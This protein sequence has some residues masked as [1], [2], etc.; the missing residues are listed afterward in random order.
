MKKLIFI[1]IIFNTCFSQ[2]VHYIKLHD[3][4]N[5]SFNSKNE[6][7][8]DIK[9]F[10][11]EDYKAIYAKKATDDVK[12]G[13]WNINDDF[14]NDPIEVFESKEGGQMIFDGNLGDYD[15]FFENKKNK[16]SN[17][18][19][20]IAFSYNAG[21]NPEINYAFILNLN[22]YYFWRAEFPE[23]KKLHNWKYREDM[24][25]KK[26]PIKTIKF[27]EVQYNSGCSG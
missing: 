26:Q 9:Y 27:F 10:H 15:L 3:G 16:F 6:S 25:Y 17:L 4:V 2:Q 12:I 14:I 13:I 18:S 21:N 5:S 24:I 7:F 20:F 1:L 22:T 8:L 11:S 19:N 23:K